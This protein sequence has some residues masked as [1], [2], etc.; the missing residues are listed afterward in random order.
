MWCG[1]QAGGPVAEPTNIVTDLIDLT[2]V[3]LAELRSIDQPILN[4]ALRRVAEEAK[5]SA[6]VIAGF[7][8]AI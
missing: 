5:N 8:A 2:H 6:E 4:D 7:Q 1:S 3:L